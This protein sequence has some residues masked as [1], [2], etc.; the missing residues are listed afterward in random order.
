MIQPTTP[1]MLRKDGK[2]LECGDIH[3]YLKSFGADE[4]DNLLEVDDR[5]LQWYFDNS[6]QEIKDAVISFRK[7]K[8]INNLN[9]LN[10]LVNNEFCKVRTSN[11]KYKYASNNGE[12]YFRLCNTD[13]FNW[14]NVIWGVV[15]KEKNYIQTVTIM[16]DFETFG[17]QFDYCKVKGKE[18]KHIPVD[19]F[20][21]M[22]GNPILEA[23][24]SININEYEQRIYNLEEEEGEQLERYLSDLT[25]YNPHNLDR[26]QIRAAYLS[27]M[28]NIVLHEPKKYVVFKDDNEKTKD[29]IIFNKYVAQDLVAANGWYDEVTIAS[30]Y[31][32]YMETFNNINIDINKLTYI[33]PKEYI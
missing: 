19:E 14:Y 33:E 32:K 18:I 31:K 22:Q 25:I 16:R 11:H 23:N 24:N 27:A 10:T 17:K 6:N 29:F 26:Q 15:A 5:E 1:Y 3:P 12:I 8:T 2:L 20:L 30:I 9:K 21:T 13:N 7:N 4:V 28:L